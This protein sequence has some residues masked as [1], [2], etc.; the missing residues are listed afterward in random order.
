MALTFIGHSIESFMKYVEDYDKKNSITD[1]S[2]NHNSSQINTNSNKKD[3][4][5][6]SYKDGLPTNPLPIENYNDIIKLMPRGCFVDLREEVN[7]NLFEYFSNPHG[8]VE[9]IK[10]YYKEVIEAQGVYNLQ[11]TYDLLLNR[12]VGNAYG[13]SLKQADKIAKEYNHTG[14]SDYVY[15]DADYHYALEEAKDILKELAYEV[16]K[17]YGIEINLNGTEK[18]RELTVGSNYTFNETWAM[19]SSQT[20][21]RANLIDTDIEPPQGFKMF[22]KE[23][24]YKD[25]EKKGVFRVSMG[26]W[27]KEVDVLFNNFLGLGSLQEF[28]NGGDLILTTKNDIPNSDEFNRFIRNFN[29]YTR[30]YDSLHS[31][32]KRV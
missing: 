4:V 2:E 14:D 23:G 28:F 20:I 13:A 10:K 21:N 15:Y 3:I 19:H 7:A 27:S 18:R 24:N 17:E 6:I 22:Y 25:N 11:A 30:G 29:I 12:S 16:S 8:D 1:K 9:D 31:L 26:E 32:W 5:E